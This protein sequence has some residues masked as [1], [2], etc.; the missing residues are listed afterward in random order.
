M[1][2]YALICHKATTSRLVPQFDGYDR[3]IKRGSSHARCGSAK[4]EKAIMSPRL[5]RKDKSNRIV[6]PAGNRVRA[7]RG[8]PTSVARRRRTGFRKARELRDHLTSN[9]D[10]VGKKFPEEAR[11]IIMARSSTARST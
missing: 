9:A 2:R 1:I 6:A 8:G 11:K 4:V 5:A 10:N 7:G 3:Q